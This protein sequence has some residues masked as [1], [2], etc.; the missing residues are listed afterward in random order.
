M[1][2]IVFCTVIT[3]VATAFAIKKYIDMLITIC[4][5]ERRGID[6]SDDEMRDAAEFVIKRL[7]KV[8]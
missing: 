5:M 1:G 8:R 4:V 2:W 3:L 6:P 7:F